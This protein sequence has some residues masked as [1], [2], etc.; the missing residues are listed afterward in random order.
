MTVSTNS[1]LSTL[2]K[3]SLRHLLS[4]SGL[5]PLFA[6]DETVTVQ[7]RRG[8]GSTGSGPRERAETPERQRESGG[9]GVPPSGSGGGGYSGGGGGFSGG[10]GSPIGGGGGGLQLPGGGLGIVVVIIIVV[11]YMI[12]G[13]G[14][15]SDNASTQQTTQDTTAQDNQTQEN[16]AQDNSQATTEPSANSEQANPTATPRLNP[17]VAQSGDIAGGDTWTV[18]LYQD[19]DDKVLE[20]DILTDLNEAERVGSTD[21]VKVVA[22]LDRYRG[23]FNGDGDWTSAKRFLVTKDNDLNHIASKQLADMGEVD[24]ADPAT[25]VDFVTWAMKTYPAKKYALILSD[26]GMGW[27]GGITD[28]TGTK[29]GNSSV[30]LEAAMS[31]ML[32]LNEIDGAL[33]QIREQ[34]G[35][36]KFELIG[37]DACLMAHLEVFSALEPHARYAVASQETEPA[38]GWAYAGFLSKLVAKPSMNGGELSQDIVDSYISSDERILDDQAR[39]DLVGRGQPMGG[40]FDVLLGSDASAGEPSAQE[41]AQEFGQDVTLAAVDLSKIPNVMM[42]VNDLSV[43]LQGADQKQVEKGRSSVQSFTS[44]FGKDVPP[45]YIDLGSFVQWLKQKAGSGGVGQAADEVNSAL[46]AAVIGEKNGSQLPGATGVSIYFPVSQLYRTPEAGPRSYVPIVDRFAQESLWDDFLAYHYTGKKFDAN[47]KSAA[48][49]SRTTEIRAPGAGG[50]TLSP[51]KLSATTVKPG[52][53]ITM[54]THIDGQ[55]VGYVYFFTGYYDKRA[56]SILTVDQDYL[57]SAN[58]GNINGIYYP[59]WPASGSFNLQFGWE[60]LFFAMTDGTKSA[61]A[62]FMPVTYGAD[63]KDAVYTVEGTYTFADDGTKRAARLYFSDGVLRH[64]FGFTGTDTNMGA[65]SEIFPQKG[66]SFT[67]KESWMDL[68]ANGNVASTATQDGETL[69]FGD[70]PFTWKEQDAAAGQ[71]VIGFIVEDLDGNKSQVYSQVEVQ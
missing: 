21:K 58:T 66:D 47:T 69:T 56:N 42:S 45:S 52:G 29:S 14:G 57:E 20:K 22:Q 11:L 10:G 43:A 17:A 61:T 1:L 24:M 2:P 3:P 53:V 46:S 51:I 32:Y 65:M 8:S 40:L 60:P 55:N 62:L 7:R 23:G 12:F 71:Y 33:Q 5:Q 13:R 39:A 59:V 27:P 44:V 35:L 38:L 25:L 41:V 28:P 68:D 15:N 6:E 50:I 34:T 4:L 67:I 31:D 36:D 70:K 49:P 30:P 54:T 18:M 63:Q 9:G 48:I 64:I 37:L 19:A 26:H 16:T